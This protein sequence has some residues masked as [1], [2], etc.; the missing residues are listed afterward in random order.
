MYVDAKGYNHNT[1]EEVVKADLKDEIAKIM[2]PERTQIGYNSAYYDNYGG[3][4]GGYQTTQNIG[5]SVDCIV[6]KLEKITE[7]WQEAQGRLDGQT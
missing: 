2:G 4:C 7:A 6:A 5:Y 1:P 3:R